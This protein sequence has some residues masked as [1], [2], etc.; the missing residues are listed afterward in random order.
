M[1]R[2]LVSCRSIIILGVQD[3]FSSRSL[4]PERLTAFSDGVMAVIITIMALGIRP[5]DGT[6]LD[7]VGHRIPAL[8]IYALSFIMIGIYWNNHHHLLRATDRISG[9]VMWSNLLLLFCL[10][11]LPVATEWIG[12]AYRDAMPA[13]AWGVIALAAAVA[14]SILVRTIIA[15]NEPGSMVASAIGNDLKGTVSVGLYALGIGLAF[16]PIGPWLA[17]ACFVA[18]AALWFVPDRRFVG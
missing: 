15:A 2:S 8:L 16:L 10:S 12:G 1:P 4:G 5:P 13:A 7:A 3:L 6:S 18:V 11:L 9:A 14:Y 17:Y